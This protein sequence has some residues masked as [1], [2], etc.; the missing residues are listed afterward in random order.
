MLYIPSEL[1]RRSLLLYVLVMNGSVAA[2][3]GLG[4]AL[5]L[6]HATEAEHL[7]AISSIVSERHSVWQSASVGLLWVSDTPPRSYLPAP[8]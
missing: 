5:G 6:K 2:I 3:L 4:F 7:A 8:S 1:D